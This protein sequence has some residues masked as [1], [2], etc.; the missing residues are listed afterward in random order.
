MANQHR[1]QTFPLRSRSEVLCLFMAWPTM[2]FPTRV[3]QRKLH[4]KRVANIPSAFPVFPVLCKGSTFFVRVEACRASI[5][6][7]G[8]HCRVF[9]SDLGRFN[10]SSVANRIG[11]RGDCRA[12]AVRFSAKAAA[13]HHRP[14][15]RMPSRHRATIFCICNRC[16]VRCGP[17]CNDRF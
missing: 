2:R 6:H 12:M 4:N 3:E 7:S 5:T 11:R 17:T 1:V 9:E 15:N 16:T 14:M 8:V 13:T 10:R